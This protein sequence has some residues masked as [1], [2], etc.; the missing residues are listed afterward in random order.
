MCG[1]YW[2]IEYV[3]LIH[4]HSQKLLLYNTLMFSLNVTKQSPKDKIKAPIPSHDDAPIMGIKTQ[5]NY[6]T[7]NA[8]SAI[9]ST[10]KSPQNAQDNYLVSEKLNTR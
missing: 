4:P 7:D 6:V 5:K 10:P 1:V 2:N 3:S 9:L 8:V